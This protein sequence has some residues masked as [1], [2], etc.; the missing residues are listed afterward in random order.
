MEDGGGKDGGWGRKIL[1]MR[2]E[3]IKDG[4]GKYR[5]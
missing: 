4:G 1:R 3:K 5:G 2:E